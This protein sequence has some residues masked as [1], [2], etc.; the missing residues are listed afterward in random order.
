MKKIIDDKGRF[1]GLIS[2][3]DVIVL[4]A[5]IVLALVVFLRFSTS[6]SPVTASS[7]VNVTYT[8]VV[9]GARLSTAEQILPG[10]GLYTEMGQP[11][12]TITDVTW[13]DAYSTEPLVDGT[14]VLGRVHERYDV[15]LTVEAQCS[16][17][18]GRYY[19][20]RV[21]EP[22]ANSEQKL[23]TKYNIFTAMI[24]SVYPG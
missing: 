14:I 10:D 8:V 15:T 22:S 3:I 18:D 1:F 21:F 19:A 12:G 4:I 16:S 11:I 6:G 17:G 23:Q 2:F 7:T 24:A 5:V 9:P 13:E 20:N